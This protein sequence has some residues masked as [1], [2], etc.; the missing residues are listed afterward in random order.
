[1]TADVLPVYGPTNP[2]KAE[3][4]V[5]RYGSVIG[6][7][8]KREQV[9]RKLH[10]D[11]WPAILDRLH[12]SSVRNYSIFVAQLE[13]RKYLFSYFEYVGDDFAADMRK[14]AEDPATQEWWTHTDPCQQRLPGTAD[15]E[16]WLNLE[17]VFF[18][19]LSAI[20]DPSPGA[21]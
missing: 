5:I 16:Q 9:Y 10:A 19:A 7:D 4:G 2:V 14:I 3:G 6:L 12:L 8:L 20:T 18:S 15:G 1:M 11:V 13:G 21:G 17:S